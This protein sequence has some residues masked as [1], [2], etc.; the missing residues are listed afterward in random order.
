MKLKSNRGFTIMEM[1]IT[2]GI[3]MTIALAIGSYSVLMNRSPGS[4]SSAMLKEAWLQQ[5]RLMVES[6][7][8]P[9]TAPNPNTFTLAMLVPVYASNWSSTAFTTRY[10]TIDPTTVPPTSSLDGQRGDIQKTSDTTGDALFDIGR[11]R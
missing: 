5:K 9:A 7:A 2:A 3:I 11:E 8:A 1:I 10:G 6:M 4:Q